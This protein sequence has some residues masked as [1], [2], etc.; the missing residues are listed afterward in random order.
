MG[1]LISALGHP[2]E[3]P[4]SIAQALVRHPQLRRG[5]ASGLR[6]GALSARQMLR[7]PRANRQALRNLQ[8]CQGKNRSDVQSGAS[9]C[10]TGLVKCVFFLKVPLA[11]LGSTATAVQPISQWNSQEHFT[12][13]FAQPDAQDCIKCS[14]YLGFTSLIL[15]SLGRTCVLSP[16]RQ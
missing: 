1:T 14:I 12:K 4:L 13:P 10:E 6:K 2:A 5:G 15:S 7:G 11:C 3:P 9:G 16:D 8:Q